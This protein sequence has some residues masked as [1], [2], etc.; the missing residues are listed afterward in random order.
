MAHIT[1]ASRAIFDSK[2]NQPHKV[3]PIGFC[4]ITH[5]AARYCDGLMELLVLC[6]ALHRTSRMIQ[7]SVE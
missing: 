4:I 7:A 2:K 6:T 1:H 3:F 5:L